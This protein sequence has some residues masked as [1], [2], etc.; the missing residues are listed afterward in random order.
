MRSQQFCNADTL[1]EII[2]LTRRRGDRTNQQDILFNIVLFFARPLL[3]NQHTS[4]GVLYKFDTLHVKYRPLHQL[5]AIC[6][7]PARIR[8]HAPVPR[9]TRGGLVHV[10]RPL[11]VGERNLQEGDVAVVRH[12]RP[13]W[14]RSGAVVVI[15]P[16]EGVCG[17]A[18]QQ[19]ALRPAPQHAMV[20]SRPE[21]ARDAPLQPRDSLGAVGSMRQGQRGVR[22]VEV[23]HEPDTLV[24]VESQAEGREVAVAKEP[25]L[26]TA[27]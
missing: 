17:A 7:Q 8:L 6:A 15:D 13:G 11:D 14:R 27:R 21:G 5:R 19:R 2:W 10:A 25:R 26:W 4:P 24:L 18:P 16:S 9:R 12:P 20:G 23:L 22:R 3:P 1:V